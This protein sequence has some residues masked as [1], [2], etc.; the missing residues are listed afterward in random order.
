VAKERAFLVIT[1]HGLKFS[2]NLLDARPHQPLRE[3]ASAAGSG[4]HIREKEA[5]GPCLLAAILAAARCS[6]ALS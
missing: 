5:S 1:A 2:D 4:N 6:V 3:R